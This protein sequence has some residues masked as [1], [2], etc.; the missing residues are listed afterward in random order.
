MSIK[1]T[2]VFDLTQYFLVR[3]LRPPDLTL[4]GLVVP[5]QYGVGHHPRPLP[6]APPLLDKTQIDMPPQTLKSFLLDL[7]GFQYVELK[8]IM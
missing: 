5:E 2:N 4:G 8:N 6:P 7:T 3:L 1:F